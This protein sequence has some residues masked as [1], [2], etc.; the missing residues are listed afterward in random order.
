MAGQPKAVA[1]GRQIDGLR[2]FGDSDGMLAGI[3]HP[4]GGK[5]EGRPDRVAR[6]AHPVCGKCLPWQAA[7]GAL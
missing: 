5:G 1:I 3:V 6:D 2:F 4:A 7:Q